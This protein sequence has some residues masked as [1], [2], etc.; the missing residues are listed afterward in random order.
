M[1]RKG[2][3]PKRSN[4]KNSYSLTR[5]R[6]GVPSFMIAKLKYMSPVTITPGAI[7]LASSNIFSLNGCYDPDITGVGSQP[8][9]FDQYCGSAYGNGLYKHYTVLGARVKVEFVNLD[10]TYNNRCYINVRDTSS[11]S[12]DY[13]DHEEN[14]TGRKCTVAP[15]GSGGSIKSLTMNWSAKK[16]FGKTTVTT[17]RDLTGNNGANPSEQAFLHVTVANPTSGADSGNVS[18]LVQIEYLVKFHS[19]VLP[20][21]S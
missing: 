11:P 16:W 8:R 9:C 7:G 4:K 18:C 21:S 10:S 3:Y 14:S 6:P 19:P 2:K 13:Y 15:L 20:D 17:E 5:I 1:P 12:T